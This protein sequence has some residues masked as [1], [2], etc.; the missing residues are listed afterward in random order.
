MG[1]DMPAMVCAVLRKLMMNPRYKRQLLTAP[2]GGIVALDWFH[3]SNKKARIADDAPIVLVLHA[4]CGETCHPLL[5]FPASWFCS[6]L[7][8]SM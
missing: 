7:F 8:I 2:D 1:T 4:L 3:H 5:A 6:S